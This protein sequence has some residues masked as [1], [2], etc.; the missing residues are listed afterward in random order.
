ML[1]AHINWKDYS[2]VAHLAYS[3]RLSTSRGCRNTESLICAKTYKIKPSPALGLG[4]LSKALA[5]T[6]SSGVI[7]PLSVP[8]TLSSKV[9][10]TESLN[11]KNND[12]QVQGMHAYQ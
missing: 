3:V 5:Q 1:N 4:L 9:T 7:L 8:S 10:L 12:M 2:N 6:K 11:T